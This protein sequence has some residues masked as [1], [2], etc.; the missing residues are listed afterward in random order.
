MHHGVV[1]I[2]IVG[3]VVVDEAGIQCLE[4]GHKVVMRET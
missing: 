1:R 4:L 2:D 3:H